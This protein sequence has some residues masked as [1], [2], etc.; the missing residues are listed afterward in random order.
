M[1]GVEHYDVLIV[2]AGISGLGAAYH[3]KDQRP[4][5]TFAIFDALESYGGTWWT[6]RYPGVRSDSDLFTFGYRF[7][8]WPG[9]PIASG[10]EIMK[11]LGETIEE[12]DLGRH[13][14]YR[15]RVQGASWSSE[16]SRWTVEITNLETNESFAVTCGFLWMCQGYYRHGEGYK[17]EWDGVEDFKGEIYHPQEWPEEG[18]DLT[19]KKVIVIGSGATAATLIPAIADDAAHVT[20]LQRSPTFY[21]SRSNKNELAETLRSLD[22]DPAW[23]H[24]IVRRQ[25]FKMTEAMTSA[26]SWDPALARKFMVDSVRPLLP[27][28][29]DVEKHFTP[30]YRVWQQRVAVLPDGDL[31]KAI[32]AGKV[33]VVTDTIGRFTEEGIKIGSGEVIEADVIITATGFDLCVLGDLDFTVDGNVIDPSQ[34]VTYRGIM[35]TELPNL[36]YIFGY[37]RASWTLRSDI[38]SDLVCRILA[39]MDEKGATKVVPVLRPE[40]KDMELGL[41]V[42]PENFNPGYLMRTQHLMPKRG[43]REPWTW[44]AEY[45][46]EKV[47]LAEADLEDGALQF[48]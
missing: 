10:E 34:L 21:L 47:E 33:E 20:M 15:H 44:G 7:K 24:E 32:S 2:G 30:S 9:A 11:Y 25:M 42:D 36:A 17:P 8:P 16:D 3:L 48:T 13:I 26:S 4:G 14:R 37:F 22:V 45:S 12:N 19:D 28:G 5:T 39:A 35:F 29:Y 31:F 46:R 38:I 27:D 18:V 43:D 41:W 23:T 1:S 40:D 6:H